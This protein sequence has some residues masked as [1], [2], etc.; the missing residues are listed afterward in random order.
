[1]CQYSMLYLGVV[2]FV[3]IYPCS[4]I[5]P[6]PKIGYSTLYTKERIVFL[7]LQGRSY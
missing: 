6:T 1:M 7:N 5:A 2:A 3:E 4:Q